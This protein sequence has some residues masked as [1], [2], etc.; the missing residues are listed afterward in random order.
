MASITNEIC[1]ENPYG[2]RGIIAAY[3]RPL[4]SGAA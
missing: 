2:I 1:Q 3:F 4:L